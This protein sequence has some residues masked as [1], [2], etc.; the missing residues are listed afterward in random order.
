MT[1]R[2]PDV[3]LV[4]PLEQPE[5]LGQPSDKLSAQNIADKLSAVN[6]QVGAFAHSTRELNLMAALIHPIY[7]SDG[8]PDYL[9]EVVTLDGDNESLADI[10]EEIV[11]YYRDALMNVHDVTLLL[12]QFDS[13]SMI[14]TKNRAVRSGLEVVRRHEDTALFLAMPNILNVYI[15]QDYSQLGTDEYATLLKSTSD[16]DPVRNGITA[17]LASEYDRAAFWLAQIT[18]SETTD[19]GQAVLRQGLIDSHSRDIQSYLA[20]VSGAAALRPL[21]HEKFR[22]DAIFSVGERPPL[23]DNMA[24]EK[25]LHRNRLNDALMLHGFIPQTNKE[26]YTVKQ[27]DRLKGDAG[28]MLKRM[29]MIN[30]SNR[31]WEVAKGKE[32]NPKVRLDKLVDRFVQYATDAAENYDQAGFILQSIAD[33][34][35]T[36]NLFGGEFPVAD[37]FADYP[38][39]RQPF[40]KLAEFLQNH[41]FIE[42]G[43]D[44]TIT[45]RARRRKK[46]TAQDEIDLITATFGK[47]PL[48]KVAEIAENYQIDQT[49]RFKY[50]ERVVDTTR[51][52]SM[53]AGLAEQALIRLSSFT[54]QFEPFDSE[55]ATI[56]PTSPDE[57]P[58]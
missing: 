2:H 39:H 51:H 36:D 37:W 47:L 43:L 32:I 4:E 13:H 18:G 45:R 3:A 9:D 14:D 15:D 34:P 19:G 12:D 28:A 5:L 1:H 40:V 20:T 44:D 10:A 53:V 23:D 21:D 33:K 38:E 11:G 16:P 46:R 22:D 30:E 25:F 29:D 41:A 57:Q 58:F 8:V 54:P 55:F 24:W 49:N 7:Q 27:L 35:H 52:H 6:R 42:N 26:A 31:R 17:T 48:N 56:E 50:W